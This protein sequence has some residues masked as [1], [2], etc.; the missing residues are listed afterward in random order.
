MRVCASGRVDVS[1]TELAN[2][3]KPQSECVWRKGLVQTSP[4]PRCRYIQLWPF[5]PMVPPDGMKLPNEDHTHRSR[6]PWTLAE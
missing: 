6:S 5:Q 1:D 4:F 2:E 3:W